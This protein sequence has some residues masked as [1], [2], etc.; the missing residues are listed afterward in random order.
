MRFDSFTLDSPEQ[1][2]EHRLWRAVIARKVEEW[3]SG[4]LRRRRDAEAFL[5]DDETDFRI[6]CDAAGRDQDR[7]R[8]RLQIGRAHV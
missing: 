6:V 1:A 5:F 7:L 2:P 4:P 3:V 8:S